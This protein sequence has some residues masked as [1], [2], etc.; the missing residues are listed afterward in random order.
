[1]LTTVTVSE[2]SGANN[3]AENSKIDLTRRLHQI[4]TVRAPFFN[5]SIIL[6]YRKDDVVVI[7]GQQQFY[8]YLKKFS[9][10]FPIMY[11]KVRI[12]VGL[13]RL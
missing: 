13:L 10:S 11:N 3:N 6:S 1:M 4:S 8:G 5:E 7:F 2:R 12:N 9:A